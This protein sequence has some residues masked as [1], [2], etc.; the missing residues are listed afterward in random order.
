MSLIATGGDCEPCFCNGNID[1]S[2]P[3]ACNRIS[4]RCEL[5]L[6]NTYGDSC[7]RCEPWYYGDAVSAAKSCRAC[8]CDRDGTA[9]C[10]HRSGQCRCHPGVEG[11]R[12]DRCSADHFGFRAGGC[13]PCQCSE[14]SEDSQCDLTTGQCRCRPG[15]TGAKCERC[16]N[17]FWNLGPNGCQSCGCNTDYAVGGGCNQ[18]TGQCQC[19]PGV[20]GQNC[21]RCPPNWVLIMNET[22]T[23]LP[24][25]KL[26]FDYEEGCFPCSSCVADIMEHANSLTGQ[27]APVM[28]EF[29]ETEKSFYAYRRLKF[30]EEEID[31]LRPEIALLDP[32]EG[33]K[34][35]QPLEQKVTSAVTGQYTDSGN[36]AVET[37]FLR[38]VVGEGAE[39]E[40]RRQPDL[41]IQISFYPDPSRL[42]RLHYKFERKKLL[43]IVFFDNLFF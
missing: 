31:R 29:R 12:C 33:N 34:R 23:T 39:K 21:D 14:A 7:E 6:G 26:P 5:C 20:V 43:K 40:S 18:Y 11:P 24:E 25:W 35:I 22:R 30:I 3:A 38:G 32:V 8:D 28:E 36:R 1:T 15:V 16:L 4:G 13:T 27:L 19:L 10:D 42:T 37:L 2:D 17:G 41:L 9:E